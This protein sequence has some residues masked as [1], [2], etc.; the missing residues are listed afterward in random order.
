[1]FNKGDIVRYKSEIQPMTVLWDE[2][3][4][5]S[6]IVCCTFFNE[7]QEEVTVKSSPDTLEYVPKKVL[8][9]LQNKRNQTGLKAF[10]ENNP[11][12]IYCGIA[13]ISFIAGFGVPKIIMENANQEIVTK[14]SYFTIEDFN[15]K[16]NNNY[17]SLKEY[18]RILGENEN[19]KESIINNQ[20]Q[21]FSKVIEQITSLEN[22]RNITNS[23]LKEVRI[24]SAPLTSSPDGPKE[25]SK[26]EKELEKE[27]ENIDSEIMILYSKIK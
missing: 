1:M 26:E 24:N 17:V 22:K 5:G 25:V 2:L 18:N 21:D 3:E 20:N 16:I 15:S 6:E 23:K 27:I 4:Y 9:R 10:F 19:L 8:K 12:I 13:I 11:V 14:G 7:K